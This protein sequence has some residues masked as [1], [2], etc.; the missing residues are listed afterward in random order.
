MDIRR[1]LVAVDIAHSSEPLAEYAQI[2][3]EK[4]DARLIVLYVTRDME[5]LESLYMPHI[6]V[7]KVQ[8][9]I[10]DSARSELSTFC[11]T[12]FGGRI[13]YEVVIRTGDAY[14]E[15]NDIIPELN[16]DLVVMGTHG[17]KGLDR[18][19]FGSTAER[20]LRS[21]PCPVLTVKLM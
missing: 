1:I 20:V 7:E 19:F 6:S 5:E 15:I 4:L 9:E 14:R 21:V 18:F 13:E 16:V 12:H 2:L 3:A 17:T 10:I 8:K 11:D